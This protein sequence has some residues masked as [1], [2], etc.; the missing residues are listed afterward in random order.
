VRGVAE[1]RK[2]RVYTIAERFGPDISRYPTTNLEGEYQ[3][4]NAAT[5]TLTA[6]I[7][8]PRWNLTPT[9]VQ[10][11][12][13]EVSWPGRWQRAEVGGKN[14]I[15]DASHNPEGALVLNENLV[16]LHEETKQLPVVIVGVLGLARARPLVEV[17]SRHAKEIY[18]VVPQQA[19]ACSFED[20]QALVPASF[21]GPVHRSS[22]AELFPRADLCTAGEK[23]DLV[24]VTGSIYLLG[25]IFAR[26]EPHRGAGEGR[27]QDF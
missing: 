7:L 4:W 1:E 20:L 8:S 2:C 17:V 19:R 12:L 16:R 23:S 14:L 11:A 26:I 3:R 13:Q 6:E 15:L 9:R 27:L 10:D 24:V 21:K 25:E 5:A 18:F 22:V